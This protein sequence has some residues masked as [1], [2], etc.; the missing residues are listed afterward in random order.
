MTMVLGST[1]L[2]IKFFEY[3]LDA[4]EHLVLG[5]RFDPPDWPEG[6]NKAHG[7][8]FFSFYYVMTGLHACH[9][10][11]GLGVFAV[12]LRRTRQGRYTPQYVTP[13]EVGGLYWHFVDIVWVFLFP[14]LYLIRH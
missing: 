12:L 3:Y 10:V 8:L 4:Q 11:V 6:V 14:L 9:M 2:G 7:Q 5:P 13:L 1:F